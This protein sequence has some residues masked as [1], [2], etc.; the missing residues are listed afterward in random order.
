MRQNFLKVYPAFGIIAVLALVIIPIN[1]VFAWMIAVLFHEFGHLVLG[2][3]KQKNPEE[4]ERI[5]QVILND[6]VF[7][8][9]LKNAK[10]VMDEAEEILVEQFGKEYSKKYSSWLFSKGFSLE[11]SEL[12]EKAVPEI[13]KGESVTIN[14]SSTLEDVLISMGSI[15]SQNVDNLSEL[16]A[17]TIEIRQYNNLIKK[18]ISNNNIKEECK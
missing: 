16:G 7:S 9:R 13:F 3:V 10:S 6:N 1:W 5:L 4:Y 11:V 14:E 8:D 17:N 18:L 15:Y 2:V 12:V